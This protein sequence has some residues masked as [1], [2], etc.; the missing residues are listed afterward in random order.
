MQTSKNGF[1][2]N[3]FPEDVATPQKKRPTTAGF[4][5]KTSAGALMTTLS[6]CNPHYIRCIKPND[7]K[8][9]ND[10]NA[11]RVQHQVQY[12]GLLENVRVRRAGF[13]YR[14]PFERFLDRYKKLSKNTW[15][16][17]GEWS[18]KPIEGCQK[19]CTDLQLDPGQWQMGKTKIF[20]RHP[21]TV[22]F[23]FF[24]KKNSCC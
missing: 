24:L 16:L 6:S 12:L 10:W 17:W 19:I 23:L 4:K 1:I 20:I 15:G 3:L 2:K 5:I 14:A 18:G 11:P 22:N 7:N 13:A 9:A 8:R 21:E